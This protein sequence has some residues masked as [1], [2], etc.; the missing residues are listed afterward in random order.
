MKSVK[1]GFALAI[2]MRGTRRGPQVYPGVGSQR[3]ITRGVQVAIGNKGNAKESWG[4]PAIKNPNGGVLKNLQAFGRGDIL[5]REVC[6]A[7]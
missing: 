7:A 2:S 4:G 5:C 6:Y 1:S 3:L